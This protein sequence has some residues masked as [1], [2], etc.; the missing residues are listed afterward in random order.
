MTFLLITVAIFH[1]TAIFV[2]KRVTWIDIYGTVLF[3]I[4]FQL[5]VDT[6]LDLKYN[7]YGYFDKGADFE[8]LIFIFGIYPV[9]NILVVNFFP[10]TKGLVTK[11]I[12][13]LAW[14]IF[15]VAYEFLL[16]WNGIFYHSD[17]WHIW[18]SGLIYPFLII[19]LLLN[20]KLINFI[21]K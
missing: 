9:V 18:Y 2:R 11:I 20:L 19:I 6:Y 15:S 13:I 5:I 4:S 10:N 7:L 1:L 3:T 21:K 17:Q 8:T 14:S 12:Y 16:L